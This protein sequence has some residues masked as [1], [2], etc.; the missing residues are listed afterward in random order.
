MSALPRGRDDVAPLSGDDLELLS[1]EELAELLKVPVSW[2]YNATRGRAKQKIPHIKV[3]RYTRF[4]ESAVREWLESQ[5]KAYP[6]R[7]G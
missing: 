1:A 4:Q 5:K 6:K 7:K 2:I 3:G